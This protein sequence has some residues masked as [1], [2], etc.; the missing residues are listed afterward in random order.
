MFQKWIPESPL[1]L[2]IALLFYNHGKEGHQRLDKQVFWMGSSH[3][4][5]IVGTHLH[6]LN[7]VPQEP[8]NLASQQQEQ[9]SMI[10]I[11]FRI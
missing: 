5:R 4:Q 8:T 11:Y 6:N 9:V 3:I 1:E 7:K 10:L 2:T